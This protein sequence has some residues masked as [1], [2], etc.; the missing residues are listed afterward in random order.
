MQ[1]YGSSAAASLLTA[2]TKLF[3]NFLQ[4]EGF[5]LGV[6]DILV[7]K[8]SDKARRQIIRECRNSGSKILAMAL[9]IEDEDELPYPELAAKME[10][11]YIKDPHFRIMLDRKYKSVLDKYTNDINRYVIIH[12]HSSLINGM[13]TI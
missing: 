4:R 11:A 8:D 10:E 7:T 5:T 2:F 12:H 3:T 13:E 6:R 9:N 1:L